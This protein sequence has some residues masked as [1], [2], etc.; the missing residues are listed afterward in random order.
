M[1]R[2]K[3]EET[4]NAAGLGAPDET[5]RLSGPDE[6]MLAYSRKVIGKGVGQR[7]C[8]LISQP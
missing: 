5:A 8:W 1:P 3:G 4:L 6:L 2:A 7:G